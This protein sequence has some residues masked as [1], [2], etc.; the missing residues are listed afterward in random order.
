MTAFRLTDPE[1]RSS[2][3][4][5]CEEYMKAQIEMLRKRNDGDLDHVE[6]MR[7]RGELRAYK[8]LLALGA[9]GL[10]QVVDDED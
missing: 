4:M 3:W 8:N 2:V 6:T 9:P 10:T 5:K 1:T 7:L